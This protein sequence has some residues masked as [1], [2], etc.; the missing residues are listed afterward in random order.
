MKLFTLIFLGLLSMGSLHAKDTKVSHHSF[1]ALTSDETIT[2]SDYKD[3]VVL[4]VNTASKCAFTDQYEELESLY[5]EYKD[6][7]LVVLGVPSNDFGA[8]EPG[9]EKQIADFCR[10]TYSVS[11][12]MTAKYAVVGNNAHPF[13]QDA[14]KILGFGTGPKWNFHKYI[15]NKNGELVDYFH[16]TTSPKS[17]KIMNVLTAELAK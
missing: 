13:Y 16:S 2:L 12:P 8:Q 14:K 5:D 17:N 4:I 6:K 1:S 15:V 11:F 7:G 3:K 9:T 10:L